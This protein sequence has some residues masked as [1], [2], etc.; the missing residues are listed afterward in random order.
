MDIIF[1]RAL[2]MDDL[3]IVYKWHSDE[4]LYDTL[5]GP[6]RYVSKDAEREWLQNKVKYSNQEI[7]LMI[8]LSESGQP[9]GMVSVREIDW[10]ARTGHFTGLFIGEKAYQKKGYGSKALKVLL[11]HVFLELGLNRIWGFALSDNE[12]SLKMLEKCGFI[13]EGNLNQ[14]AYKLGAFRDVLVVGLCSDRYHQMLLEEN[15]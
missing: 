6:Y 12:P 8:C 13:V 15:S 10:I 2:S 1:L 4:D 7:N 11:N 3:D 14:H 5:V 9:I